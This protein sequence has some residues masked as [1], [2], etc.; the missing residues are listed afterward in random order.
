MKVF[1]PCRAGSQ[2]VK[3]KNTRP[4]GGNKKGLLGRKLIQL[5][6]CDLIDEVTVSTNDP[7]VVEIALSMAC[8]SIVIDDRPEH[9]CGN[10]ATTDQLIKYA[11]TLFSNEHFLWTHVTCPFFDEKCYKAAIDKYFQCLTEN[12][13]D[14]LMGVKKIQTF[15]W[16]DRGA[17]FDRSRTKWPFT[18]S[19]SPIYEVDSTVFIINSE[20]SKAMSDRIGNNPFMFENNDIDSFDIDCLDQFHSADKLSMIDDMANDI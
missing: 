11:S 20:L 8:N 5:I 12:T 10:D 1:L 13:H 3:K 2:R 15:L 18:Q 14:S 9:L 6:K 17:L 4:F 16:D 7:E 19:I